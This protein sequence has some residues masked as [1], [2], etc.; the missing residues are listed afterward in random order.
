LETSTLAYIAAVLGVA[1]LAHRLQLRLELSAAK[2]PSL[3]GHSRLARRMAALVPHYEYDE[4]EFFGADDAPAAVAEQR[5]AGFMRL[6]AF[7]TERYATTA[8]LT[9]EVEDAISDLQFTSR[10]R[11]PFQFRGLVSK[12]LKSGSFVQSSAGVRLTDLDGN[13]VTLAQPGPAQRT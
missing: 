6:A 3:A 5:R 11:V 2:H 4:S 1:A 13:Q 8:K 7:Y 10:Y 12:H 9:R